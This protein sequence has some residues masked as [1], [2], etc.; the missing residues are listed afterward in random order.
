MY[1]L[2]PSRAECSEWNRAGTERR[3]QPTGRSISKLQL[4]ISEQELRPGLGRADPDQLFAR[5]RQ[6]RPGHKD[7]LPWSEK[8]SRNIGRDRVPEAIRCRRQRELTD[9]GADVRSNAPLFSRS[10]KAPLGLGTRDTA[11]KRDRSP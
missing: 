5:A 7:D 9:H 2:P 10:L 3:R 4:L 8:G 11:F 1:G 6:T